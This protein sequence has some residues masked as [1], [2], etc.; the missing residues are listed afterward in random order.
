MN[1]DGTLT[2][3]ENK[4]KDAFTE[5]PE[6]LSDLFAGP[7]GTEDETEFGALDRLVETAEL[8]TAVG[9]GYLYTAGE[10][11]DRRIDDYERQIESFERRLEL[12]ESTLR[13]TY[14]NL[15]VALGGLQQQSGY[16]AS[17]LASLGG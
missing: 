5:N 10:S 15:E 13:R 6:A 11:K 12:R 8:A 16:L 1:R 17:Q 7:N 3:N 2:F 9:E 4:F 14:A